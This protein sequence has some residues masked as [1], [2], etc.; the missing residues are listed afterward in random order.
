MQV[1][2]SDGQA[3]PFRFSSL[4]TIGKHVLLH[5]DLSVLTTSLCQLYLQIC[6]RRHESTNLFGILLRRV[7]AAEVGMSGLQNP[8]RLKHGL[9][10]GIDVLDNV[11]TEVRELLSMRDEA[12]LF[13][14][15]FAYGTLDLR[16][17]LCIGRPLISLLCVNP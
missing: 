2:H 6:T 11:V 10:Q 16:Q 14:G 12:L 4:Q 5:S 3:I 7:P 9:W 13:P 15:N 17:I 1:L 8:G